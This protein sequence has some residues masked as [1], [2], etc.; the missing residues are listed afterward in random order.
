MPR[1]F[2][3]I[4]YTESQIEQL[5]ENEMQFPYSDKYATYIGKDHQYEPTQALFN[6]RGIDIKKELESSN[7]GIDVKRFLAYVRFKFYIYVYSHNKS[8]RPVMNY[9]IAKRGIRAYSSMYEYRN[10]ILDAMVYLGEY[11]LDN[12]DLSKISGVDLDSM[13]A[14][15]IEQLRNEDRDYPARFRDIMSPLGLNYYGSYKIIPN[16]LGKEW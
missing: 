5:E 9:I 2:Q 15:P 7:S 6:E 3:A 4:F 11:L 14:L 10:N 13:T 1:Q 8:T 12:G 16:G